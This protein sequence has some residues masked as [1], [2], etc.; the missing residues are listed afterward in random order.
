MRIVKSLVRIDPGVGDVGVAVR[1]PG[2][3]SGWR[4]WSATAPTPHIGRL[5]NPQ[6]QVRRDDRSSTL[7]GWTGRARTRRASTSTC[8]SSRRGLP[9]PG[10]E[11]L[12]GTASQRSRGSACDAAGDGRSRRR[13]SMVIIPAG[14]FRMGCVSGRPTRSVQ[15]RAQSDDCYA[16]ERP[17]HEVA[18]LGAGHHAVRRGCTVRPLRQRVPIVATER[19]R[20]GGAAGLFIPWAGTLLGTP[21]VKFVLGTHH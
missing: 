17:V 15:P 10:D 7:I 1:R 9:R 18:V 6:P 4:W 21:T 2:G 5:P 19:R 3:W 12:G 11:P 13:R 8:G 20:G 14:T 16:S